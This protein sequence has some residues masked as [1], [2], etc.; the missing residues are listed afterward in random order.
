MDRMSAVPVVAGMLIGVGLIARAAPRGHGPT[1]DVRAVGSFQPVPCTEVPTTQNIVSLSSSGGFMVMETNGI[2]GHSIGQFPNPGNPNAISTQ[3]HRFEIPLEPSGEGGALRR[4]RVGVAVNGVPLDPGTAEY[5][6]DD[7][8]SGW[9]Y[10]ALSGAINL[11]V[12]CNNAHVQ[13]TGTY[14][15]HGIPEGLLSGGERMELVG[16]AADGYPL[17]ARYG[18]GEDGVTRVMQASYRLKSGERPSG[19][20]GPYDGT[21]VQDHEYVE[22]LG[23]LDECNGR[24]GQTPEF[25]ET[26]H[27][28]LTDEFPFVPRCTVA[29]QDQSFEMRGPPP[30]MDGP[31]GRPPPP[32]R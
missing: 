15:Y 3:S 27:Y 6:N 13:P 8:S 11:G 17:Y 19:P 18:I 5:Y 20:G 29:A 9:R 14:H 10:E 23:D 21:F 22:G 4:S 2:P 7:R 1:A 30:G 25:G 24:I 16:Y 26:Y 28:V 32:R 31:E 12:D